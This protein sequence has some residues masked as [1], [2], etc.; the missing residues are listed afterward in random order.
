LFD[1]GL[2]HSEADSQRAE[3]RIDVEVDPVNRQVLMDVVDYGNGV[4]ES[5]LGRLFEPF[6][7][8]SR[9]GSGLGLYLCKELC[10]INGADLF[11]QR[12]STGESA[13]RLSLKLDEDFR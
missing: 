10:E 3:L 13:F 8:T 2:R 6:F 11:Y 9:Q 4:A 5:Q 1:N 7:T 12:T